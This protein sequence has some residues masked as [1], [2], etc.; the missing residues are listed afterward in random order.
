MRQSKEHTFRNSPSFQMLRQMCMSVPSLHIK[1]TN[2]LVLVIAYKPYEVREIEERRW[3][4]MR[5]GK[6]GISQLTFLF[7]HC[8]F[9]WWGGRSSLHTACIRKGIYSR[10]EGITHIHI[11][12][13]MGAV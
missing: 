13:M 5:R 9:S 1:S 10:R 3:R 2:Y 6:D 7:S 4:N 11:S 8:S 12:L